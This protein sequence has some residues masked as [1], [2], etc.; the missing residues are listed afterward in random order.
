MNGTHRCPV[1]NRPASSRCAK[2]QAVWYCSSEC[3]RKDWFLGH[4]S[5]CKKPTGSAPA[6]VV[7]TEKTLPRY[8]DLKANPIKGPEVPAHWICDQSVIRQVISQAHKYNPGALCTGIKNS[9]NTHK[10]PRLIS[11]CVHH[12]FRFFAF[13]VAGIV[14]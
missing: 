9:V 5:V 1:C 7:S 4:K 12:F 3:Q 6:A 13:R 2:C 8:F 10:S 14:S 11:Q